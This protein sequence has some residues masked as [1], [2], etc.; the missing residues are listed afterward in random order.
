MVNQICIT[1]SIAAIQQI[2]SAKNLGPN[3]HIIGDH[4]ITT[5]SQCLGNASCTREGIENC[6]GTGFFHQAQDGGDQFEFGARVF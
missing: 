6:L 3:G 2:A 4:P 5:L 1:F